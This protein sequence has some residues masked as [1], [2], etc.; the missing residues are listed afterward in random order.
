VLFLA[1]DASFISLEPRF[2]ADV[3]VKFADDPKDI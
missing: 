1:G 2:R 3:M